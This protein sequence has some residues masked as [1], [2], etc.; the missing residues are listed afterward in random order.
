MLS[1]LVTVFVGIAT[2]RI[3]PNGVAFVVIW[4]ALLTAFGLMTRNQNR[5]LLGREPIA[6]SLDVAAVGYLSTLAIHSVL[7]LIAFGITRLI[8]KFRKTS[9]EKAESEN[10]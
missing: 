1:A 7:F 4:A 2:K 3:W 6:L 8:A 9:D 10:S 5:E